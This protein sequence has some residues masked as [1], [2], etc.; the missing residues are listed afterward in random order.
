MQ[1]RFEKGTENYEL[2][3]DFWKFRQRYYAPDNDEAWFKEL[4]DVG[5]GIINK[6]K[7]T[8]LEKLARNLIFAHLEDVEDRRNRK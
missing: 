8:E 3:N 1:K 5:D 6:Y 2:L 7:G 4:T